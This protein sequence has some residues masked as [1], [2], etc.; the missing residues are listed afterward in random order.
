M[1]NI[2]RKREAVTPDHTVSKR[3]TRA[4]KTPR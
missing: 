1:I 3:T 2:S 4:M